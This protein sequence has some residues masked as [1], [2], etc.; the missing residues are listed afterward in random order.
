[1]TN[2]RIPGPGWRLAAVE[3]SFSGVLASRVRTAFALDHEPDLR[4]LRNDRGQSWTPS[5]GGTMMCRTVSLDRSH[6]HRGLAAE[7]W[8]RTL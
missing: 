4:F 6:G 7:P 5:P 8:P 3:W 2:C 1:M